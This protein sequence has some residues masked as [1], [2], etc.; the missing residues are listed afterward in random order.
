MHFVVM[1]NRDTGIVRFGTMVTAG[2]SNIGIAQH[3][4]YSSVVF[5]GPL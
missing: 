4:A 5:N 3:Y 1:V 2:V